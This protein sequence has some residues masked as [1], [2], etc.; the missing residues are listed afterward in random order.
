MTLRTHEAF[1]Q[2]SLDPELSTR[3]LSF[4]ADLQQTA[5]EESSYFDHISGAADPGGP[6]EYIILKIEVFDHTTS[7]WHRID[8]NKAFQAWIDQLFGPGTYQQIVEDLECN[9]TRIEEV[10]Y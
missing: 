2:L 7:R 5:R 4:S 6:A 10:L 8:N 1:L 9:A 3:G